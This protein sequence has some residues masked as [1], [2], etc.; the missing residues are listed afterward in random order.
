MPLGVAK[1]WSVPDCHRIVPTA[2]VIKEVAAHL[3]AYNLV[4]S[5]MAQAANQAG[6]TPR[7][8]SFKGAL[9]QFRAFEEQLRHGAYH[10]IA[11]CVAVRGVGEWDRTNEVAAS[12]RSRGTAR[13]QATIKFN[14]SDA[15]SG[16]AQNTITSPARSPNG[17]GLR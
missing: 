3:L 12:T 2:M 14:A 8:L 11:C 7:E 16:S 5:V 6:C 1:P 17:G 9:Q 15:A 4:R 13:G 10:R